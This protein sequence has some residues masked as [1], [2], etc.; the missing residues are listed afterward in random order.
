MPLSDTERRPE[1]AEVDPSSLVPKQGTTK[2][3]QQG[4]DDETKEK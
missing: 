3:H 2:Q 4:R 1:H